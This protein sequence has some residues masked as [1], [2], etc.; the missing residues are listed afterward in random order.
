MKIYSLNNCNFWRNMSRCN[1]SSFVKQVKDFPNYCD[2]LIHSRTDISVLSVRELYLNCFAQPQT[3]TEVIGMEV[4]L[5]VWFI[6]VCD[7]KIV[8][9]WK[10][11]DQGLVVV[12]TRPPAAAF[13]FRK[14]WG[15]GFLSSEDTVLE[16]IS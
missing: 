14:V 16:Y 10:T 2:L 12:E 4:S 6:F 7:S 3:P 5:Q 15:S 13:W 9:S 8:L 1:K 11:L